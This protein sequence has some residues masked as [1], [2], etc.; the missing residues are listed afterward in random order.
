MWNAIKPYRSRKKSKQR[1][2]HGPWLK[3]HKGYENEIL[4][5]KTLFKIL[6]KVL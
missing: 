2:I 3:L 4:V 1:S 5:I 6:R